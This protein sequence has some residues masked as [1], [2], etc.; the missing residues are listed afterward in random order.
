VKNLIA[1]RAFSNSN[2]FG[3]E[4]KIRLD[5]SNYKSMDAGKEKKMETNALGE[6]W[7]FANVLLLF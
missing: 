4:I 7:C 5:C 1:S 2:C 6:T 3:K